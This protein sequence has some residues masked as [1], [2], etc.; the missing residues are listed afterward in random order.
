MTLRLANTLW[1][2]MGLNEV[3]C[4]SYVTLLCIHVFSLNHTWIVFPYSH[5]SNH[6][7]ALIGSVS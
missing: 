2:F 1:I 3:Y 5:L 6:R 7:E 4:L